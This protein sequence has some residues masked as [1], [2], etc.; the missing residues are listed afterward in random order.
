MR[1][2]VRKI[3]QTP[4]VY[5][6]K[7]AKKEILYIG[8]AANLR[9]RVQS[10]FRGTDSRGERIAR[11]VAQSVTVGIRQTPSVLEALILE[12]DLVK[13]YQPRY[14][15]DLKDD[16]SFSYVVITKE[17][18]PR[19]MI[20]RGT[21]LHAIAAHVAYGPYVSR[22]QLSIALDI[23]RRIFPFHDRP[24]KTEKG[25]LDAQIGLCPA[26]Y[27][28]AISRKDYKKNIRAI[29]RIFE[30]RKKQ[31]VTRMEREMRE[32]ARREEFEK[33]EYLRRKIFALNH[34]RDVAL[35]TGESALP[36]ESANVRIEGY[37]ISN[38]SGQHAVGSMVVFENGMSR[39]SAYRKF[40]IKT[41]RGSDDVAMMREVLARR[42]A[43]AEW[44]LPS[45]ILLDG[46][47]G[48]LNMAQHLCKELRKRV[49]LV[50]LAKGP[51]RKKTDL[52]WS[53]DASVSVAQKT[54]RAVRDEAHRFAITY[55]RKIRDRIL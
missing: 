4:G 45:I 31:L 24:G 43:H 25:C 53:K 51:T 38:I 11:M 8:K 50:A 23:L 12:A 41:V 21:H 13:K 17:Q 39:K 14:N 29:A 54:L 19:I 20:V 44:P 32:C 42:F 30:G 40:K 7:S 18:F 6:F 48:H 26:P 52:Y 1:E 28:G 16:K 36:L 9:S 55:H 3:P 49:A 33:A 2:Q 10:Y 47:K 46:G 22:K 37:D 35:L 5:F 34:L 15:V 27:A